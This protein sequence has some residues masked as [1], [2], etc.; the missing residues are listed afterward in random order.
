[1]TIG[2][3]FDFEKTEYA[4]RISYYDTDR[5]RKQEIVKT[6][7]IT[8][9]LIS[10]HI[11][12]WGAVASSGGTLVLS[13]IAIR[14][15]YVAESKLELIRAELKKRDVPLHKLQKRDILIPLGACA[16]GM[17]VGH[18]FDHA[19]VHVTH[20][21][22]PGLFPS[23]SVAHA[24]SMNPG[25][26]I[27]GAAHGAAQQLHEMGHAI[28]SL[29]NGVSAAQD[30]ANVAISVPQTSVQEAVGFHTGMVAMQAAEKGIAGVVSSSLAT[31]GMKAMTGDADQMDG[32]HNY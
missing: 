17:G 22:T 2:D 19:A 10:S 24:F 14:R 13:A 25:D 1:M 30:L 20:T 15:V 32:L 28:M 21:C 26:S 5:L 3:F 4:H 29:D 9:G 12:G 8:A 16:A 23:D 31:Q 27:S 6:R 7:Q 18:V 11:G